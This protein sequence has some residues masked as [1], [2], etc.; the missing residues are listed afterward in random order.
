MQLRL[1]QTFLSLIALATFACNAAPTLSRVFS[2]E[3][4]DGE[5]ALNR[6]DLSFASLDSRDYELEERDDEI[7]WLV[8]RVD[9]P[10]PTHP[11]VPPSTHPAN[12][13]PHPV[14]PQGDHHESTS[15][16]HESTPPQATYDE[17]YGHIQTNDGKRLSHPA[18]VIDPIPHDLALP[19]KLENYREQTKDTEKNPHRPTTVGIATDGNTEHYGTSVPHKQ[20]SSEERDALRDQRTANAYDKHGLERPEPDKECPNKVGNCAEFHTIP[21]LVNHDSD[22]QHIDTLTVNTKTG[23]PMEM[24]PNCRKLAETMTSQT[25]GLTITDHGHPGGPKTYTVSMG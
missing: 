6:R 5:F 21:G 20:L 12:P 22:G 14:T 7:Q 24:C 4:R 11:V 13:P 25:P 3:S 18:S 23:T 2:I 1:S 19:A 8:V 10:P 17:K 9:T 16:H 15:Q